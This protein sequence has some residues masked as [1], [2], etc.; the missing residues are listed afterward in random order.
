MF[1]DRRSAGRELAL[2][3]LRYAGTDPV[4]LG[5]PRGGVVV[6]AEVARMLHGT[7]DVW[8]SRKLGMPYQPELGMGAI[9]EGPAVVLDRQ[10]L[11]LSGITRGELLELARHEM[12]EIRRRVERFRGGR[13]PPDLR[14]RTVILV[15]DGVA[16]GGTMRAAVKAVKKRR[17]ARLIIAIPVA[18]R[19]SVAE[20][21]GVVDDVVCLQQPHPLVAIGLWYEDFDQIRDEQVVRI[22]QRA[23]AP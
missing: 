21:R 11:T 8:I 2:A 1:V 16:M 5:L 7:L 20:F 18:P 6:A 9:A 14:D 17:P 4:V 3:L 13:K 12:N 23:G 22:L 15:D 19:D 10:M